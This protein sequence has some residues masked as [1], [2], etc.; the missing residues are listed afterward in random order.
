MTYTLSPD[1]IRRCRDINL[2]TK[3]LIMDIVR[4]VCEEAE[5]PIQV[6]L[7]DT[8]TQHICAARWLRSASGGCAAPRNRFG[9]T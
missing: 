6:V 1:D 7:G 8:K 2:G 9:I 5:I 4:A 3:G